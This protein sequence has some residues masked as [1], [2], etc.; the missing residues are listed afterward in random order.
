MQF[1]YLIENSASGP[2]E[3][4]GTFFQK[5]WD[6]IGHDITRLVQAFFSRYEL[7]KFVTRTN[8]ILIPKKEI[9]K[10]FSNLK[11]ISL[12]SFVNKIISRLVHG[13]L[14]QVLPKI[15]SQNQQGL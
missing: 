3:F 10:G 9:V 13:R 4:T 15:I 8:L 2:D 6:I 5:C 11:P 12:S 14:V 1:F 7:T